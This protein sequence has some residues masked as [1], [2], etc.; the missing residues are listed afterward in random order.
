MS[1]V[2]YYMWVYI[3][4]TIV[5]SYTTKYHEFVAMVLSEVCSTS[6]NARGN[7]RVMFCFI[8][9]YYGDND[10]IIHTSNVD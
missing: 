10:F 4:V 1:I 2:L 7:K 8:L 6:N 9:L 5:H 3:I